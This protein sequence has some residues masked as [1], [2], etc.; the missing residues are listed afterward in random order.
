MNMKAV[1]T[2]FHETLVLLVKIFGDFLGLEYS[3]PVSQKIVLN[4]W[5]E[6]VECIFHSLIILMKDRFVIDPPRRRRVPKSVSS[7]ALRGFMARIVS[8][9]LTPGAFCTRCPGGSSPC[10]HPC[11]DTCVV[12][13]GYEAR[14]F[15]VFFGPL[16]S[17]PFCLSFCFSR[18]RVRG[19]FPQIPSSSG[20]RQGDIKSEDTWSE[21]CGMEMCFC[22]PRHFHLYINF[23]VPAHNYSRMYVC[24]YIYVC[25]CIY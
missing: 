8:A 18:L 12:V 24:M 15:V 23:F 11:N 22:V 10:D 25:V 9:V 19:T 21:Q 16:C 14:P 7:I 6:P 3:S 13:R 17:P 1:L 4:P 2:F 5:S 20:C